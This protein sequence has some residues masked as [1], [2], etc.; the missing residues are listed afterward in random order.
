MQVS[1][2]GANE[3]WHNQLKTALG[4]SKGQNSTYSL[5]GVIQTFEDCSRL[6]DTRYQKSMRQWDTKELALCAQF[7]WLK[8]FPYPAQV[9]LS[10]NFSAA[11]NRQLE[12]SQQ[13]QPLD[14]QG[15]C[16]CQTFQ[17]WFLPC[18]HMLEQYIFGGSQ[19]EPNW[20][21]YA[22]L[23]QDNQRLDVY[24]GR[25]LDI[26]LV[27]AG[28]DSQGT[29]NIE[30]LMAKSKL[31]SDERIN[32]IKD[33]RYTLE[34]QLRASDLPIDRIDRVLK[35]YERSAAIAIQKVLDITLEQ[36]QQEVDNLLEVE[37]NW[38]EL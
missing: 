16:D 1:T 19:V 6:I 26:A 12:Q 17:K 20:K 27:E 32:R 38:L 15:E 5:A 21:R 30:F 9:V 18:E 7:N 10:N 31:D 8:L 3:G 4:L 36:L 35:A 25:Q 34:D 14:L 28:Q 22:S 24:E 13:I 29:K 23:F 11:E 2:T 37:D 33:H